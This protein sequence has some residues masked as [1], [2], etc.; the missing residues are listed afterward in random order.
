VYVS[1]INAGKT[2]CTFEVTPNAYYANHERWT[3]TVA[4][5]AG[6]AALALAGSHAWYD[7][8][9][10]LA[11]WRTTARRSRMPRSASAT[12]SPMARLRQLHQR[13]QDPVHL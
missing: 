9:V 7:F 3:F 4:A 8:T 5:R 10:R 6:R 12:T 13:R 2:P 1:F 11:T